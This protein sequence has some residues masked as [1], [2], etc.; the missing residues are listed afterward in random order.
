MWQV[1]M[2]SRRLGMEREKE[3]DRLDETFRIN[4][5]FSCRNAKLGCGSVLKWWV[6]VGVSAEV[7]R[8]GLN[9]NNSTS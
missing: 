5:P 7:G 3:R 9:N 1:V 4:V 6:E 2:T 8:W